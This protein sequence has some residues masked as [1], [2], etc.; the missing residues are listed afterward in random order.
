MAQDFV[1][2]HELDHGAP[3]DAVRVDFAPAEWR[4]L[5]VLSFNAGVRPTRAS[6]G[7][8]KLPRAGLFRRSAQTPE[9]QIDTERFKAMAGVLRRAKADVVALQGLH[10]AGEIEL[11]R[12]L[13]RSAYPNAAVRLDHSPLQRASGLLIL[14]RFPF[15]HTDFEPLR[16]TPGEER[17]FPEKG[18]LRVG[19]NG[20]AFGRFWITTFDAGLGVLSGQ[21]EL[22]RAD[23]MQQRLVRHIAGHARRRD[24]GF[25]ELLLGHVDH[26]SRHPQGRL[27][28]GYVDLVQAGLVEVFEAVAPGYVDHR[29]RQRR[30]G[31]VPSKSPTRPRPPRESHIFLLGSEVDYV[32]PE[33][34]RTL[35]HKGNNKLPGPTQRGISRRNGVLVKLS[36]RFGAGSAA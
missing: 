12:G 3:R 11:V 13:L 1:G 8:A 33:A 35:L 32:R 20:G 27:E 15:W 5:T 22:R 6:A 2:L 10:E 14:S 28:D 16:Q 4:E 29:W 9:P 21:K 24:G 34:V 25:P 30:P 26:P 23:K 17:M 19:I 31:P 36:R 7:T 18:L